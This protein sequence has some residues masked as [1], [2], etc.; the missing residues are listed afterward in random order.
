MGLRQR[1]ENL[2]NGSRKNH[3]SMYNVFQ[4]HKYHLFLTKGLKYEITLQMKL[5]QNSWNE[6]HEFGKHREKHLRDICIIPTI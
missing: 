5:A 4:S 3:K 1:S 6:A 2:T